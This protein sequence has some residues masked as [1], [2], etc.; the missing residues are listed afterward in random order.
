MEPE[1]QAELQVIK[2]LSWVGVILACIAVIAFIIIYN[3]ML[4]SNHTLTTARES[5]IAF[6]SKVDTML[7]NQ[8]TFLHQ[9]SGFIES[10]KRI[11]DTL[12]NNT[13]KIQEIHT[14]STAY[15]NNR[16]ASELGNRF[17]N[18]QHNKIDIHHG[19]KK[20]AEDFQMTLFEKLYQMREQDQ[21]TIKDL[22]H[23]ITQFSHN[24]TSK[25]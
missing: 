13:P 5:Q 4:K 21:Q 1:L 16:V 9:T 6:F 7:E 14:I 18:K 2:I 11:E 3:M 17:E 15:N 20:S 22:K 19:E 24:F 25:E 12:K 8:K 10:L 23:I